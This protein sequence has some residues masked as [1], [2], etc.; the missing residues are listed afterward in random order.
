MFRWGHLLLLNIVPIRKCRPIVDRKSTMLIFSYHSKL[1]MILQKMYL[2]D[3]FS[4]NQI[5]KTF[6]LWPWQFNQTWSSKIEKKY[7]ITIIMYNHRYLAGNI[8]ILSSEKCFLWLIN[9]LWILWAMEFAFLFIVSVSITG[10]SLVFPLGSPIRAVAS[11]TW[12]RFH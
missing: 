11:P 9:I 1:F 7:E 8:F 3:F 5:L 10:R 4:V 12:K 2:C 6:L